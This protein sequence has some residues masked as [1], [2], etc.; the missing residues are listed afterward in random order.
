MPS[1]TGN[2]SD[3]LKDAAIRFPHDVEQ[4]HRFMAE[5]E[6][7]PV[8]EGESFEIY[9]TLKYFHDPNRYEYLN[10]LADY[11]S[12]MGRNYLSALCF[13]ESIRLEPAQ[14]EIYKRLET[15]KNFLG[16]TKPG[17]L[18]CKEVLVSVIMATYNR[19][20]GILESIESVLGQTVQDLELVVINDGGDEGIEHLLESLNSG[21][22]RYFRLQKNMGHAAALNEGVRR[23]RGKYIAYLDDDDVYYPNHLELLLKGLRHGGKIAYS[24]TKMVA[25]SVEDGRFQENTVKGQWRLEF[26]KDKLM[27]NNFLANFCVMHEKEIFAEIGLFFDDLRVVMDWE[28][29][30]RAS[31]SYDFS[32][33][34]AY[35]GEYRFKESN[36]TTT[37]RLWIDFFTD[38]IRNYYAYY[39]G[40][41]A[42]VTYY[43][44]HGMKEKAKAYYYE[45]K[46]QYEHY[47]KDPGSAD[48]L[49]DISLDFRDYYF[50][51]RIASWYFKYSPRQFIKYVMEK[52]KFVLML[53]VFPMVPAKIVNMVKCR[54]HL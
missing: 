22:I 15:V 8:S 3:A 9:L 42:Y 31:L 20:V 13:L 25:G 27:E 16:A 10:K 53:F 28:F 43:S 52:K 45:L 38:L 14:S 19:G 35:T 6:K 47:F 44:Y 24:N 1:C 30:L 21:K 37:K 2:V 32:H 7:D 34:D 18:S 23:S 4:A 51:R 50:S 17:D 40:S 36:V 26:D 54:I 5:F 48:S 46:G 39:R 41:I 11:Y 29:W 49:L 33:V 12:G